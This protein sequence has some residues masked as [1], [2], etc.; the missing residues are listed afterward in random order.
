[1]SAVYLAKVQLVLVDE[2]GG[3][4]ETKGKHSVDRFQFLVFNIL[5]LIYL[6]CFSFFY[7]IKTRVILVILTLNFFFK[8]AGFPEK[9]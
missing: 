6:V 4:G 7:R 5:F 8:S 9:T 2:V 3:E 1:M